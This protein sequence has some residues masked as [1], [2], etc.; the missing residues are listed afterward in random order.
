MCISACH[1]FLNKVSH[2]NCI[3]AL[4]QLKQNGDFFHLLGNLREKLNKARNLDCQSTFKKEEKGRPSTQHLEW[5]AVGHWCC[6]FVHIHVYR[7]IFFIIWE[8]I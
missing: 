3:I 8:G 6:S 1:L 5:G 7:C 4:W 2:L